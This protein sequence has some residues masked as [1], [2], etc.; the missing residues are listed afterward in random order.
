MIWTQT[1][2]YKYLCSLLK[3]YLLPSFP[4]CSGLFYQKYLLAILPFRKWHY[5]IIMSSDTMASFNIITG[6]VAA[7]PFE[8]SKKLIMFFGNSI[9]RFF[10]LVGSIVNSMERIKKR[11]RSTNNSS[12]FKLLRRHRSIDNSIDFYLFIMSWKDPV[13]KIQNLAMNHES[14]PIKLNPA[15]ISMSSL[16]FLARHVLQIV[17][18]SKKSIKKTL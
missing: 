10:K 6:N 2:V 13:V 7:N 3:V 16:S 5:D 9:M 4:V 12:V 17:K 1:L 11:K 15:F 14:R 8:N 18:R